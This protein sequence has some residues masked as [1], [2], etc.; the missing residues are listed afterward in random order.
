MLS[1]LI[2][3]GPFLPSMQNANQ[4]SEPSSATPVGTCEGA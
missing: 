1:A 4:V 3:L 2:E